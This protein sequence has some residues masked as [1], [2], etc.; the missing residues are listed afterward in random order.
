MKKLM[1]VL[2][3]AAIM[4]FAAA[5]LFAGDGKMMFGV[6]AGLNLATGTGDDAEG[7]SMK[8]GAVGGAFLCYNITEIFAIQ[9]ELLFSMKGAKSDEADIDGS[10][11]YNYFEIPLLLKVNLPTEG[12]IKPSL[13]AGPAIGI[14]M[15]A[16][17]E[18]EDLKDFS[19]TMDVGI[20]AGAGVGYQME[21]GMLF[22]EGRYEV[23]MTTVTDLTD[24]EL[25]AQDPPL[26]EQPDLK[27]S[28]ISIMV[29][30]GFAF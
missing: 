29:G 28:V 21:K 12:K 22:L 4:L 15:S 13:Y 24:E 10:L 8:T 27:N 26:T 9:P 6:K 1:F 7:L 3:V 5:P 14:L 18:D 2:M 30:Y 20:V 23:G 17:A 11:K 25:A 16:K 19:K